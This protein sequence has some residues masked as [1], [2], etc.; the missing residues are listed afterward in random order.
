M[1]PSIWRLFFSAVLTVHAAVAQDRPGR[2]EISVPAGEV[3]VALQQTAAQTGLQIIFRPDALAGVQAR[4][5][6]GSYFPQEAL[7]LLLAGTPLVAVPD[8]ASGAFAVIFRDTVH[9]VRA[10]V[11]RSRPDRSSKSGAETPGAQEPQV[12]P[13]HLKKS[14][15]SRIFGTIFS[16]GDNEDTKTTAA[17]KNGTAGLRAAVGLAAATAAGLPSAVLA[18]AAT[19]SIEG[20]VINAA[21][22]LALNNARVVV[23]GTRLEVFTDDN[24]GYRLPNIPT[25]EVRLRATYTGMEA[26]AES[27]NVTSGATARKDFSLTFGR[28]LTTYGDDVVQLGQFIVEATQ[29]S[30]V[31]AAQ[32]ERKVAPNIKD[33]VVFD[34][35]GDLG[36]GNMGEYLKYTPG[37]TIRQ[38]GTD[39]AAIS[40]R[41]MPGE[42]VVVLI[43]GHQYGNMADDRVFALPGTS[44]SNVDRIEV[45]KS[46]TPDRPAN[47]VGGTVNVISKSARNIPRRRLMIDASATYNSFDGIKPPGLSE[48][49]QNDDFSNNRMRKIQPG[50]AL[51][52]EHPVNKKFA[53]NVRLQESRRFSVQEQHNQVWDMVNGLL[54]RSNPQ[55]NTGYRSRALAAASADWQI[56]RRDSLRLTLE[57]VMNYSEGTR[58]TFR[59]DMGANSRTV[60]TG[61]VTFAQGAATGV[62]SMRSSTS[63]LLRDYGTD[64]AGISYRH[65]GE[66]YKIDVRASH[67]TAYD[68]RHG[69]N[70]GM[71]TGMGD[72][73]L[74]NVVFRM[75]D[76]TGIYAG[77]APQFSAI[78]RSGVRVDPYDNS[79]MTVPMGVNSR[80]RIVDAMRTV[81]ADVSRSFTTPLPTMLKAGLLISNQRKDRTQHNER[82]NFA[83]PAGVATNVGSYDLNDSGLSNAT[84]HEGTLKADYVSPRKL[85][86]FMRSNPTWFPY[87][88]PTSFTNWARNSA[89]FEETI[90]AGYVRGDVKFFNNQ[91]WLVGGVRFEETENN[92]EGVKDDIG[93]TYQR[94][95]SGRLLRDAAGRPIP[96]TTDALAS[97]KLRY[98]ERGAR[99]HKKY[100]DSYPS[101][102][103]TW[104]VNDQFLVRAAIASTMGRPNLTSTIPGLTIPDPNS[105]SQVL[106][107]A[108][109]ALKPWTARNY[110]L[111]L[112]S[113]EVKGATIAVSGFRKEV[114]NFFVSSVSPVTPELM[115]LYGLGPEFSSYLVSTQ[116]NGSDTATIKGVEFSWR[117]NWLFL[118]SWAK[119]VS[120]FLNYTRTL[121]GGPAGLS[122]SSV[123]A[124]FGRK[125]INYGINYSRRNFSVRYN[126][127][128]IDEIVH[129]AVAASPTVLPGSYNRVAPQLIQDLYAEYRFTRRYTAYLSCRNMGNSLDA[130]ENYNSRVPSVMW[131]NQVRP[132]GTL[133]TLGVRAEF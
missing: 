8:K 74:S 12:S 117:Q 98:T 84:T 113:Y 41:G 26:R 30:A 63:V 2:V 45:T 27:L 116:V 80:L 127:A 28:G 87:D 125:S 54:T 77:R 13:M 81:S 99:A 73:T 97:A 9:D 16:N 3:A 82:W 4:A 42:T 53:Y 21:T 20:R 34:E 17:R 31:A 129:F 109:T 44:P 96:I 69:T 10:P 33:V 55:G 50:L 76:I 66:I 122:L 106:S 7:D 35:I 95:A 39:A 52:W 47:S 118:P 93:A 65:D 110:D 11:A 58:P 120:T 78:N 123:N 37:I 71:F 24:G 121:R 105:T 32:N 6:H 100:S 14:L 130:R 38:T 101:L 114:K 119:G 46:P 68:K 62:D 70:K 133:T 67:S 91:V 104:Y 15:L 128:D 94:D 107:L 48:R 40:I 75:E 90:R 88:A 83:P 18:Q 23:E 131:P 49:F 89:L 112:E 60:L 36:D 103:A 111:S 132:Y 43:D 57:S 79:Y 108:N 61:P 19:G 92:G 124:G 86:Q 56:S 25:G 72:M 5:V 102:N 22:G 59:V 64:T 1:K 29:I 126:V 51:S 115:E 85:Y